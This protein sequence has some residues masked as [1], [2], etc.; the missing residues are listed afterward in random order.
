MIYSITKKIAERISEVVN[1]PLSHA[2]IYQIIYYDAT[3]EYRSHY[4]GWLHNNSEKSNRCMKY[5]G[6]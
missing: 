6:A 5:E 2:E 3:Q 1:I 4:D